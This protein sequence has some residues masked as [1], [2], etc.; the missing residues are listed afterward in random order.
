MFK[1]K[2]LPA[3]LLLALCLLTGLFIPGARAQS[4]D[5]ISKRGKLL[6]AMDTTY[7]PYASMDNEMK[8]V[9]FEVEIAK[10]MAQSLGVTLEVVPVNS[11]NRIPFLLTNKADITLSTLTITAARAKQVMFSIPYTT[12]GF[13]VIADKS[14]RIAA[15]ADLGG[16]KVGV[17]RG[18]A[19]DPLLIAVAPKNATI[20]RLDDV[21]GCMQALLSGQVDAIAEGSLIPAKMNQAQGSDK[22]E[23]KF[24]LAESHL[25]MGVRRGSFDLLQWINTF[26]YTMKQSGKLNELHQTFLGYPTPPLPTF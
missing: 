13:D 24:A 14:R 26:I 25:G 12:V 7:Q 15:A 11:T 10:L 20:V 22:F 2:A 18:G 21:A 9:G 19:A 23:K 4:L 17:I 5:D 3:L 6:V 16:L 1:P 8:A